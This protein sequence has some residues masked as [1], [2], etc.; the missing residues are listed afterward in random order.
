MMRSL[1]REAETYLRTHKRWGA[2]DTQT[3]WCHIC[4]APFEVPVRFDPEAKVWTVCK[5]EYKRCPRCGSLGEK[6]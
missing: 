1:R 3:R 4:L 6:L 5:M 2:C